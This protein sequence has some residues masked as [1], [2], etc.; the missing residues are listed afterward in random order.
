[1]RIAIDFDGT[2]VAHC[3][4]EVGPNIGAQRVLKKLV[5][6]GHKL[7]LNTMRSNKQTSEKITDETVTGVPGNYLTDA[8][9]WFEKNDIPLY[10]VGKDPN[11]ESWTESNKC[12]AEMYIDDCALGTPLIVDPSKSNKPFVDWNKLEELLI[13]GGH[14]A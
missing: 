4:P 13:E 7:I 2:V 6:N 5:M 12:Y 10:A 8:I 1:M 11:Q 9:K 3:F 14:I